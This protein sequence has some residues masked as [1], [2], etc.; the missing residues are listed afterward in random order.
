MLRMLDRGA[1]T[2]EIHSHENATSDAIAENVRF[3]SSSMT[4]EQKLSDGGFH[5]SR[6]VPT[7][8]K[9]DGQSEREI[10]WRGNGYSIVID[11]KIHLFEL[12]EHIALVP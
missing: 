11:G 4:V 10:R 2:H 8:E 5:V 6:L 12:P 1:S 9:A 3:V 7:E